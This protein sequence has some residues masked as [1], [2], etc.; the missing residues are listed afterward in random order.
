MAQFTNNLS[1]DAEISGNRKIKIQSFTMNDNESYLGFVYTIFF[2]TAGNAD[3][4]INKNLYAIAYII[5]NSTRVNSSGN[6]FLGDNSRNPTFG[7]QV[8]YPVNIANTGA[9]DTIAWNAATQEYDFIKAKM[10]TA[11][12]AS[13]IDVLDYIVKT[14]LRLDTALYFNT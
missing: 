9:A 3:L 10:Q 6:Q 5:N 8:P 13:A 7:V 1:A 11:N 4:R 2:R 14:I 12:G